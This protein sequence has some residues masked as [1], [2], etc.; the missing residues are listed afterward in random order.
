MNNKDFMNGL[1]A[2]MF[3]VLMIGMFGILVA[4]PPEIPSFTKMLDEWHDKA[5][6][7]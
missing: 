2:G 6:K 1:F 4:G 5:H 7:P 3:L